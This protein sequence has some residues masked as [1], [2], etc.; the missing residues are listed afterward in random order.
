MRL[1]DYFLK[2]G[3]GL[4][5]YVGKK[6]T[7]IERELIHQHGFQLITYEEYDKL[8]VRFLGT[9]NKRGDTFCIAKNSKQFGSLITPTLAQLSDK[10]NTMLVLSSKSNVED[11]QSANDIKAVLGYT[12]SKNTVRI[13]GI[14]NNQVIKSTGGRV[15][16]NHLTNAC[17]NKNLMIKS[18]ANK[19]IKRNSP[20]KRNK[21]RRRY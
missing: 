13:N 15:L 12:F 3:D 1:L 4:F 19:T 18:Y 5:I 7:I 6:Q 16:I 11:I 2:N 20:P 14:C 9:I 10:N 8:R 21:T 17:K